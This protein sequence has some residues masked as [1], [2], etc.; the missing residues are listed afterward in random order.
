MFEYYDKDEIIVV[1]IVGGIDVFLKV[2]DGWL[3]LN[4]LLKFVFFKNFENY[5]N[6]ISLSLICK[7]EV[8]FFNIF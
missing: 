6:G 8:R 1:Y 2:F 4:F 3:L 5:L 7:V